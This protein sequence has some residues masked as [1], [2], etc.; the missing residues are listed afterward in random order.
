MLRRP[1]IVH[2]VAG[3]LTRPMDDQAILSQTHAY[4]QETFLYIRPDVPLK[5][6][7]RLIGKGIIDS[8]GVLE[9][10]DFI[11]REF[12]VAVESDEIT[13]QN[14]GSVASIA[15]FVAQKRTNGTGRAT[16][17]GPG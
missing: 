10:I 3:E 13:D 6:D 17:H 1:E 9:L 15:S 4:I 5:D 14:F 7:E 2:L 12:G 16:V 11:E 8:M